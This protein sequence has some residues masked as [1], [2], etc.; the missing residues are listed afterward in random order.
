MWLIAIL[1]KDIEDTVEFR[2]ERE[3]WW[4]KKCL[5]ELWQSSP[6]GCMMLSSLP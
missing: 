2:A 4:P 3:V 6:G 5:A 1:D